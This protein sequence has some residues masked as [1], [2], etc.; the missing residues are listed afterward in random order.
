M[1]PEYGPGYFTGQSC[2]RTPWSPE[3]LWEQT[4]NGAAHMRDE[5]AAWEG[6]RPPTGG[7]PRPAE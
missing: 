3:Q 5:F 6:G 2:V 7:G 1:T 4:L